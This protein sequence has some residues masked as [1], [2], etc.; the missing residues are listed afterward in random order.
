ME[1]LTQSIENTCTHCIKGCNNYQYS[2]VIT[3]ENDITML[4][5]YLSAF[6]PLNEYFYDYNNTFM[7]IG[8]KNY[9][10]RWQ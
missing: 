5:Y 9:F 10:S 8:Y 3:K 2:K 6:K 4:P 7:D 1:N